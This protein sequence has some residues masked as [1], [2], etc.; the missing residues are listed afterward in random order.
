MCSVFFAAS[1]IV[2][3]KWKQNR[4]RSKGRTE[5]IDV[6]IRMHTVAKERREEVVPMTQLVGAG[7]QVRK[8]R[9]RR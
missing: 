5:K 9:V 6:A 8:G 4:V 3:E 1:S 7:K 2:S